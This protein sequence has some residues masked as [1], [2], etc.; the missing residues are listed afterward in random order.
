MV[1]RR[2]VPLALL[3]LL[4]PACTLEG[5]DLASFT[6]TCGPQGECAAG[7]SCVDGVCRTPSV[8]AGRDGGEGEG[9]GEGEGGR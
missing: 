1:T 8:D 3:A 7:Q 4:A 6:L 5:L 9:E 2:V